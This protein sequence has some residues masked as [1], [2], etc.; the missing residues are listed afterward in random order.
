MTARVI[1]IKLKT[2]VATENPS[3]DF[4]LRRLK[5]IGRYTAKEPAPITYPRNFATTVPTVAGAT[6]ATGVAAVATTAAVKDFT[7]LI[8]NFE[9]IA[10]LLDRR[11]VLLIEGKPLTNASA[12]IRT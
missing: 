9:L 5:T 3:A 10:D 11:G 2:H 4:L 8:S 1:P 7:T 12:E 6:A